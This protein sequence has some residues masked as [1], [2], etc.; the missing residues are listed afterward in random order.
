MVVVRNGLLFLK[1]VA[2]KK[3]Q[4]SLEESSRGQQ[5]GHRWQRWQS[6][7]ACPLNDEQDSG[8]YVS[9][10]VSQIDTQTSW[11]NTSWSKT[12]LSQKEQIKLGSLGADPEKGQKT[13]KAHFTSTHQNTCYP[14]NLSVT[15]RPLVNTRNCFCRHKKSY[16]TQ[17]YYTI[18]V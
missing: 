6:I 2:P 18:L 3:N 9:T 15:D 17:C 11:Y 8:R 12:D 4:F 10:T 14:V 16:Y 13:V 7:R 1:I 5:P